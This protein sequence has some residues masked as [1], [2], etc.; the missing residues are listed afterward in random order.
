MNIKPLCA[1]SL[2]HHPQQLAQLQ[3]SFPIDNIGSNF[4][5]QPRELAA[6]V[7]H[8]PTMRV[9]MTRLERGVDDMTL[10]YDDAAGISPQEPWTADEAKVCRSP[11]EFRELVSHYQFTKFEAL[12]QVAIGN[13][14]LLYGSERMKFY[15]LYL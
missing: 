15:G 2:D 10:D 14:R 11:I 13:C 9:G 3:S 7:S 5:H 8:M 4:R 1:L 12:K 6:S